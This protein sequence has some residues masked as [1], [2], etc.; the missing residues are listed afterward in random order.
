MTLGRRPVGAPIEPQ[1][2]QNQGAFAR[3]AAR[4][5][6]DLTPPPTPPP[7][8]TNTPEHV[9][10]RPAT[11]AAWSP[12][13]SGWRQ[14]ALFKFNNSWFACFFN[15]LTKLN[16]SQKTQPTEFK[17]R[18]VHWTTI[19]TTTIINPLSPPTPPPPPPI[20]HQGHYGV[21][22]RRPS[23]CWRSGARWC[24]GTTTKTPTTNQRPVLR[25]HC[26]KKEIFL[27][28][29]LLYKKYIQRNN[30][31]CGHPFY[32]INYE[33]NRK[34]TRKVHVLTIF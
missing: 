13:L 15:Q 18:R 34:K 9:P 23:G 5:E 22:S 12:H 28:L 20:N 21:N 16:Q 4:L 32:Y 1:T 27:S 3:V 8:A 11:P 25:F 6:Q 10:Y 7:T 33:E 31:K 29:T 14:K 17:V 2:D 26:L 24:N 19:T 30:I